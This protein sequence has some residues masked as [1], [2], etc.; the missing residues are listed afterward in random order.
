M[1]WHYDELKGKLYIV[2]TLASY[3]VTLWTRINSVSEA[4][5]LKEEELL[6]YQ[7]L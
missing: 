1:R 7:I 2:Y 3:T 4:N 5:M 6:E